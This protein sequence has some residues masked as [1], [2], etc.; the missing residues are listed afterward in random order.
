MTTQKNISMSKAMRIACQHVHLIHQ[1]DQWLIHEPWE[2]TDLCEYVEEYP[3]DLPWD[4]SVTYGPPSTWASA[5]RQ[6]TN[7]RVML[8]LMLLGWAEWEAEAELFAEG[9]LEDRVRQA[10]S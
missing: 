5:R 4:G 2:Y 7:G 3:D 8:T 9:T 10:L 6:V 1:G